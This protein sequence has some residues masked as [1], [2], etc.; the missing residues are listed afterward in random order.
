MRGFEDIKALDVFEMKV[1]NSHG[2]AN[3]VYY[4]QLLHPLSA[5]LRGRL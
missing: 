5:R 1:A 4:L 2:F 3:Q